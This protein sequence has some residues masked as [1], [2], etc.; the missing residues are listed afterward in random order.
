FSKQRSDKDG[1]T[2][3]GIKFNDNV[4]P[5]IFKEAKKEGDVDE[6]KASGSLRP[7][8]DLLRYG[9][10]GPLIVRRSVF[11]DIC[12][13]IDRED[14]KFLYSFLSEDEVRAFAIFTDKAHD[15]LWCA[16]RITGVQGFSPIV[17]PW[18]LT[19]VADLQE[20]KAAVQK[21][22]DAKNNPSHD[23]LGLAAKL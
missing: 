22:R 2:S 5:E 11:T 16:A 17:T 1:Q 4:D 20:M 21:I 23:K 3:V 13:K 15:K 6:L 18:N 19:T 12:P 14:A 8:D 9:E 7:G 10:A